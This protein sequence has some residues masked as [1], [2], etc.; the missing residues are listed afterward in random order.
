MLVEVPGSGLLM[1][2]ILLVF[3]LYLL[4][5]PDKIK[6][7]GYYALGWAGVILIFVGN[8]FLIGMCESVMVVAQVLAYIGLLAAVIGAAGSCFPGALPIM[9][10]QPK[11]PPAQP[12]SVEQV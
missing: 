1:L 10:S 2:A 3:F 11:A 12:P 7:H 4:L 8:F 5:H 6:R 9:E